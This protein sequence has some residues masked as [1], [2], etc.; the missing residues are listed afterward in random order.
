MRVYTFI[1]STL[2]LMRIFLFIDTKRL[3]GMLPVQTRNFL[4][5]FQT[6]RAKNWQAEK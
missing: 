4:I 5:V 1:H 6:I 3:S 2:F